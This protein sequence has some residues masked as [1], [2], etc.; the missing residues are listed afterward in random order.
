MRTTT[1][2]TFRHLE[3]FTDKHGNEWQAETYFP[4][5]TKHPTYWLITLHP[6]KCNQGT[7]ITC[8]THESY[9]QE[10]RKLTLTPQQ[11]RLLKRKIGKAHV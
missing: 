7:G 1:R 4:M 6:L 3:T 2:P 11:A 5:G 8:T 9:E 10:K